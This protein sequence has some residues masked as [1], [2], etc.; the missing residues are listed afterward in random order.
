MTRN[1]HIPKYKTQETPIRRGEE[2]PVGLD[3]IMKR[4]EGAV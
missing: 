3:K 1:H 4:G 2:T